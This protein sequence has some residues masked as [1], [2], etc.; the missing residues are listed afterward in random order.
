MFGNTWVEDGAMASRA[1]EQSR[2]VLARRIALNVLGIL[3]GKQA[4]DLPTKIAAPGEDFVINLKAVELSNVYPSWQAMGRARLIN[5]AENSEEDGVGLRAI[6]SEALEQNLSYKISQLEATAGE[7]EVK[8]A[9]SELLPSLDISSNFIVIDQARSAASFG[10]NQPYT[11]SA[12]AELNQI[13]FAEPVYANLR[14]QELIQASRLA[15]QDQS[16]L[17]AILE[18]S[19]AYFNVLLAR[20]VVILQNKNVDNSRINLNLAKNK[21]IVG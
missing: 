17:D 11:W 14:I 10:S 5:V 13:V 21:E 15:Q 6:I 12:A 8:L 19:E 1:P 20:S 16:E 2:L 18:S 3:E 4:A 7:Q 9:L